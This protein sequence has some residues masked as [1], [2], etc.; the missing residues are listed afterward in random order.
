[1]KCSRCGGTIGLSTCK[2][3]KC[4]FSPITN[5]HKERIRAIKKLRLVRVNG[6]D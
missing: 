2:N 1:M 3:P 6:R 5:A 4:K